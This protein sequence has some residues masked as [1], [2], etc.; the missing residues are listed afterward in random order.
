[1][2]AEQRLTEAARA[3]A[4]ELGCEIDTYPGAVIEI[5]LK[6]GGTLLV[7]VIFGEMGPLHTDVAV[8]YTRLVTGSPLPT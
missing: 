8:E 5:P 1:M 4:T 6:G 3:I 2:I 7:P